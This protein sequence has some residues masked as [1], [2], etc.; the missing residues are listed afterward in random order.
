MSDSS[1]PHASNPAP[2]QGTPPRRHDRA[3]TTSPAVLIFNTVLLLVITAAVASWGRDWLNGL[4][5]TWVRANES[6][7]GIAT[8]PPSIEGLRPLLAR[9]AMVSLLEVLVALSALHI[10]M[11]FLTRW[12]GPPSFS[13]LTLAQMLILA[14]GLLHT[15]WGM[16]IR[17]GPHRGTNG[18][19]PHPTRHWS[20]NP[21]ADQP[22]FYSDR[23]GLKGTEDPGPRQ[24]GEFRILCLGDSIS[25]GNDLPNKYTYEFV[26]RADLQ[27]RFPHRLWRVKNGAVNGY[28]IQQ[29]LAV[30][31]ELYDVWQPDLVIAEF[32]HAN[33]EIVQF[34]ESGLMRY[35][36]FQ[37][38]RGHLF[39][40]DLYLWLRREIYHT[41]AHVD[42]KA[43]RYTQDVDWQNDPKIMFAGLDS[44]CAFVRAHNIK[45]VFY[46]PFLLDLRGQSHHDV[47]GRYARMHG[48]PI[49][50]IQAKWDQ[51]PNITDLLQDTH[52]PNIPGCVLQAR[53]LEAALIQLKLIPTAPDA[54]PR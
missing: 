30:L 33:S 14:G 6:Y 42:A 40:S 19:Y 51:V 28:S 22:R 16:Q 41:A 11:L 54:A 46:L 44:L 4:T 15:E 39:K 32:T 29:S 53:D 35:R 21:H 9:F 3:W 47:V 23:F 36:A 45:I 5:P 20:F 13:F 18:M 8:F 34:Y 24:P 17:I 48:Y 31:E 38:L 27:K 37:W 2:Q 10:V 49:I 26:M 52:H 7:E 12:N 43:A 1:L 25:T 50:D